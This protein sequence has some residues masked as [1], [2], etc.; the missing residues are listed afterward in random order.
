M[1]S[2]HR[3][4]AFAAAWIVPTV[5][6]PRRLQNSWHLSGRWRATLRAGMPNASARRSR[7]PT[8]CEHHG[9][10][11]HVPTRSARMSIICTKVAIYARYSS[12]RQSERSI[13][14]QVR[15]CRECAT[16]EGWM[17]VDVFPDFALS[18]TTR[19]GPV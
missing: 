19:T 13:E 1:A 7:H 4:L 15:L 11:G 18:G 5:P 2:A 12:D 10:E 14:D 17:V 16:Q 9:R 3:L 8:T 6:W